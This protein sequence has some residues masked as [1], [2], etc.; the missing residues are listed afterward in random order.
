[1]SLIRQSENELVGILLT[2]R[3]ASLM[4]PLLEILMARTKGIEP[5][6]MCDRI[7][8]FDKQLCDHTFLSELGPVLPTPQQVSSKVSIHSIQRLIGIPS[9]YH[10]SSSRAQIRPRNYSLFIRPTV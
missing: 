3:R 2:V 6:E 9:R 10:C 8:A 7:V 5:E 1:M 4:C